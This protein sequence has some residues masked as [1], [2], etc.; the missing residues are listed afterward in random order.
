MK[1]YILFWNPAISSYKLDDFQE[2]LGELE[3]NDLNWAVWEH[4]NASCG[5]RFFMVRCGEGKTGICMSGYFASD[6]Y[7]GEDWSGKGRETYYVDLDP[8]V[9]I[10]PEYRAILTSEELSHTIPD[11]DWTGGHSGRLLEAGLAEQLEALWKKFLDDNEEVFAVHAA[12]QDIDQTY[13]TSK[14]DDKQII[15]LSLDEEG[16]IQ[17][18]NEPFEV[19]A[20]G[21]D[22]VDSLVK[23]ITEQIYQKTDKKPEI[24]IYYRYIEEDYQ[25]QYG[26]AVR[27]FLE[28]KKEGDTYDDV[29]Y[30]TEGQIVYL[31][32]KASV[33]ASKLKEM[34]F[35]EEIVE[36][37]EAM[38][39][40]DDETFIQ[41]VERA[42]QNELARELIEDQV[43][44]AV[45]ISS[46]KSIDE[47][48]VKTLNENLEALHYLESLEIVE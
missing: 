6:P 21:Y 18:F 35:S 8:D 32:S 13:Y 45:D 48:M 7:K 40:K 25:E 2:K 5:D 43:R 17:G 30:E 44:L 27:L 26:K 9:M 12:K 34:D 1:T 39:K 11:F 19:K 41:Y 23:Q 4:E 15:Y 37:V 31:L 47:A 29:Y 38:K 3:Y 36:A 16:K 33:S 42:A 46:L 24:Q 14:N 28:S 20:E 10:H 22:D